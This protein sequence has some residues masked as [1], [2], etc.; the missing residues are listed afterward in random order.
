MHVD[1]HFKAVR[2]TI[3]IMC[4]L[5]HVIS[6]HRS[7]ETLLEIGGWLSL[8][9]V[10]RRDIYPGTMWQHWLPSKQKSKLLHA[11]KLE[12]EIVIKVWISNCCTVY[13]CTQCWSFG[14]GIP[15]C[16]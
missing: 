11:L 2:F 15:L 1:P 9:R 5:W 14:L 7:S 13:V 8:S 6:S 4:N 12:R 3:I 16:S 10:D